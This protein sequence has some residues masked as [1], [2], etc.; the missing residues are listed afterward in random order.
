MKLH[1][2]RAMSP[3]DAMDGCAGRSAK[4]RRRSFAANPWRAE[5][6]SV[7]SQDTYAGPAPASR[8]WTL[9]D[10]PQPKYF[11]CGPPAQHVNA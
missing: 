3:P 5:A 1:G 11:A 9:L 6:F 10:G 2:E 4:S 7:I 8:D